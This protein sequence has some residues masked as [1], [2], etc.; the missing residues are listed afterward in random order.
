M[1]KKGILCAALL[2]LAACASEEKPNIS[3][4]LYPAQL[5]A[6]VMQKV[7]AIGT[8]RGQFAE[9]AQ[10]FLSHFPTAHKTVGETALSQQ[11]RIN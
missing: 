5:A 7:E 9:Y 4:Q 3:V 11:R 2:L 10:H 6:G 1:K 8:R